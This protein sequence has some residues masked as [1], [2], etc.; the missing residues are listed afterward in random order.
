MKVTFRAS[1]QQESII[2]ARDANPLS[3]F[4]VLIDQKRVFFNKKKSTNF[5]PKKSILRIVQ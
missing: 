5:L 1:K 4:G 2:T 3:Q